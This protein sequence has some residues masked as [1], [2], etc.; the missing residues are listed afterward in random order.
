MNLIVIFSLLTIIWACSHTDLPEEESQ[1]EAT[2]F[3]F[4]L[5]QESTSLNGLELVKHAAIAEQLK[6][7]HTI[8]K[9]KEAIRAGKRYLLPQ[10]EAAQQKEAD[11][12]AYKE[13]LTMIVRPRAPYPPRPPRGCFDDPQANCGVPKIN[14]KEYPSIELARGLEHIQVEIYNAKNQLVGRGGS[15]LT[16][17][18]D[19]SI[20]MNIKSELNGEGTLKIRPQS[21]VVDEGLFLDIPVYAK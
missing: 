2:N 10:L 6:T 14:L 3:S 5:E 12:E 9:L 18:K 7:R 19:G 21:K 11:I 16:K 1:T 20:L 4:R 8:S 17:S 15:S 13:S